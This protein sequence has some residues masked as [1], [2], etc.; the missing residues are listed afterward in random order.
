MIQNL[1]LTH[2]IGLDCSRSLKQYNIYYVLCLPRSESA[3]RTLWS[4]QH[5]QDHLI[6]YIRNQVFKVCG[7]RFNSHP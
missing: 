5:G 1:S 7:V 2:C 6:F 4:Q 3:I